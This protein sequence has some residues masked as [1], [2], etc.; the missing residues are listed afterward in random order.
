MLFVGKNQQVACIGEF[1]AIF[2]VPFLYSIQMY[3]QI[4]YDIFHVR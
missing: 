1:F 3:E 2:M 4:L